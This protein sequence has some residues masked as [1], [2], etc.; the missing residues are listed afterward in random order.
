[1]SSAAA[2]LVGALLLRVGGRAALVSILGLDLVAELGIG[3]QIDQV[4]AYAQTAGPWTVVLFTGAWVV[5]K[6]FLVDVIALALAFSSGVLFGGVLEGALI[7]AVGATL[8]SLTA[9][10]LS[11][12]VLQSKVEKQMDKQPVARALAKVVEEDGF[13]TVVVLRWPWLYS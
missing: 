9:L 7:S 12:G 4:L 10:G 5:A 1:M 11:R 13:K 3:D 6:V 2:V 8:G